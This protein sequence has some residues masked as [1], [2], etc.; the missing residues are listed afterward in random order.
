MLQE[1]LRKIRELPLLKQQYVLIM[2]RLASVKEENY[3]LYAEA[4]CVLLR[5]IINCDNNEMLSRLA[6]P[7]ESV[8]ISYFFDQNDLLHKQLNAEKYE[9]KHQNLVA[10]NDRVN[11]YSTLYYVD[12]KELEEFK[13]KLYEV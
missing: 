8:L 1:L 6:D 10:I 3:K 4:L 7:L 5:N 2:L 12:H 11:Y 9:A 13:D